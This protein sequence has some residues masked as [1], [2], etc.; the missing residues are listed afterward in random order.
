MAN[1]IDLAKKYLP[2][3]DEVYAK[4]A[5]TAVLDAPAEWVREGAQANEVLIPNV[6]L[7]GLGDYD[8][9]AG[10]VAGDVDF[11][12]ETHQF[13]QDRGRAFIIDAQDNM[14]TLDVAL[15][16]TTGQFIRTKVNPEVDAYR[17]ATLAT[18][19]IA[20]GNKEDAD[21]D[22]DTALTAIDAGM[23]ALLENEVDLGSVVIFVSPKVYTFLKQSSLITRQFVVNAGPAVINR[24]VEVLD[25]H[26]IIVVP[27]ARFYSAIDLLDGKTEGEEAGGYAKA[28]DALDLNF[29]LVDTN[30]VL[31]IKKTAL[32]RIFSPEVY[33]DANAWKFDYRLYH[34]IFVPDNKVDG[35]YAHT[36]AA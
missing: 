27:Q 1:T 4:G 23:E 6:V 24:E 7:N 31:G 32:P 16:A 20:A 17:F 25:G 15:A 5:L 19:A 2:M 21:L 12:W 11:N 22:K 8:R 28:E 29:V 3:L 33:Q 26:P 34:D 14:E 18:K 9:N 13:T 36:V 10:Y 35:I 30:A